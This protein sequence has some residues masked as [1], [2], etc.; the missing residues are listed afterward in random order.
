MEAPDLFRYLDYRL[1][2]ADW[3]EARKRANP[4]FSH[5]AFARRAGQRSPS[6]LLHVIAG[7]RNLT[8]TTTGAFARAMYLRPDEQ[9]FF[10]ALVQLAQAGSV[11]DRN[12]AW[13]RV[14]ATRRF[15]EARR[16]EGDG[17]EYLSAWY[18]PAIRELAMCGGFRPDPEWIAATLRPRVTPSQARK[19]LELLL[20]L[21]LL[22]RT[23]DGQL[24]AAEASVAT[25]HE[26]GGLASL[27]YHRGMSERAREAVAEVPADQRHYCAVT[28]SIPA[29]LVPRL[30]RE[31]DALQERLLDL[32]DGHEGPRDHVYQVN[33]QLFPL[34]APTTGPER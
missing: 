4:R 13:E 19:A 6:L 8:A 24:V 12:R 31:L 27:N 10:G 7:K 26:V 11:E 2:L 5:R 23:D 25:P 28:V 18:Y 3:F 30:K 20:S 17:F 22:R 14:R 15:R 16:L 34:S 21:G 9:E 32:C 29:T 1:F 33:L